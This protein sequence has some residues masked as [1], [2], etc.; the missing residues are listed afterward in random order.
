MLMEFMPK[1][2]KGFQ[3]GH[4]VPESVRRR[5]SESRKG[6]KQSAETIA[7]RVEKLKGRTGRIWT[8]EQREAARLR[9]LGRKQSPEMITKRVASRKGYRHSIE[10]KNK[11]AEAQKDEKSAQWK[12][13]QVGYHGLH[14]W[15][16]KK[17]GKAKICNECSSTTNVEWSNISHS[18]KRNINDWQQLCAKCHRSFD[19]G[20]SDIKFLFGIN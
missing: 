9:A 10:T 11:I 20:R 3:K 6:H 17:L 1:G 14:T 7:K 12:G 13:D 15:V 16:Y 4:S 19:K 8:P 18:Y 5:V 2:T